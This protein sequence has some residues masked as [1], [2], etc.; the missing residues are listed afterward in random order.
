MPCLPVLTVLSPHNTPP[1]TEHLEGLSLPERGRAR[2]SAP[3]KSSKCADT[4]H[5]L[6]ANFS[7]FSRNE[8]WAVKVFKKERKWC[9]RHCPNETQGRVKWLTSELTPPARATHCCEKGPGCESQFLHSNGDLLFHSDHLTIDLNL[10]TATHHSL[11]VTSLMP[12]PM[13]ESLNW[14]ICPCWPSKTNEG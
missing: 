5:R 12:S 6:E 8:G 11:T 14:T 13:S 4:R 3:R 1:V 7:A 9:L 10:F 2:D